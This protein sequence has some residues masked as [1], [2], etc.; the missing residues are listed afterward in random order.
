MIN[1]TKM[2]ACLT[3]GLWVS[4]CV[5]MQAN[6]TGIESQR[7]GRDAHVMEGAVEALLPVGALPNDLLMR[8]HITV[9]WADGAESFDSVLQKQGQTLLVLGLGPMNTVGFTLTLDEGGITFDNRSGREMPFQATRILADVQ[10]VFY[11]WIE[12]DS[13]CVA[14]ERREVRAGLEVRERIG[15]R[16]LEERSFRVVARPD[17]GE[18]V[19]RYEG[20][21]EGS[22]V[23]SRAVLLNGWFGY[24]L[25]I[26]TTSVESID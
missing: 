21:T 26:E 9:Q 25:I 12:N 8:Q 18:I 19:V 11:P 1:A 5:W 24:E 2:G 20:W 17:R 23:P 6:E 14:C 13:R 3:L 7:Q 22:L 16:Y 10:R 4:G 15:P